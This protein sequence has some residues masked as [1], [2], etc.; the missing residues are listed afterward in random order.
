MDMGIWGR[1]LGTLKWQNLYPGKYYMVQ[2]WDLGLD[3]ALTEH[4]TGTDT[5]TAELR[6][7]HVGSGK[8]Y[9]IGLCDDG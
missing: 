9:Y 3:V 7:L 5:D 6:Q 1:G 4:V 2:R 8:N